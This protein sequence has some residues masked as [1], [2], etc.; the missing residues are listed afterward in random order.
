MRCVR[1]TN[2]DCKGDLSSNATNSSFD[3]KG[4]KFQEKKI[5]RLSP[6]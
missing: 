3:I 5:K 4:P 6:R 2:S 1:R